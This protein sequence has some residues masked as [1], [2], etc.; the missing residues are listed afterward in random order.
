MLSERVRWLER[1]VELG[2][3]QAYAPQYGTGPVLAMNSGCDYTWTDCAPWWG[4]TTYP[5]IIVV[6]SPL[7]FHGFGRFHRGHH[8]ATPSRSRT[9]GGFHVH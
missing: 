7:V 1:A 4:P 3:R 5:G 2:G 9:S 8:F 6:Q